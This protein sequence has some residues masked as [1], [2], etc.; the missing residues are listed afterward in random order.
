MSRI[1]YVNG[2][3]LPHGSAA[4]HIEDR[5]YQFADGVYEVCEVTG[6]RLV[7][8]TRHLN[9]LERSLNELKIASPMS[10][11][12]LSVV[13]RE[14]VRRNRVREGLV[15]MQV[16]RGVAR[17]DHAFPKPGTPPALVITAKSVDMSKGDANAAKGVK[18]ITLPD[19]RW[20]RVD[21]K[22]VGLLPNCLAKQAARE[23][24]AYEAWLVDKDGF[25]TEGSST[26]AWIV[27]KDGVLVTRYADNGILKG[28][29]RTTLFD[30][31]AREGVRIEE[32]QFSVAE[33]QEARE[34]FLTSATT[35]VMPIV[36]IDGRPVGNG[37]PGSIATDLRSKFHEVAEIA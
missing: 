24:G 9:R 17:R 16:T 4:V 35:I 20:E 32:R 12:A 23:A 31:C 36:A 8:E 3:Y 33:A 25:V 6:G 29:T 19:N 34:C 14:T 28:I 22:S 10:R 21:I 13:L 5:G 1:A 37:A 26:N 30:L 2:S 18:V 7:D 27:T 15:Y 11:G